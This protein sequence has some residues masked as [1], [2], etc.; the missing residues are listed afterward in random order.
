MK[1]VFAKQNGFVEAAEKGTFS[2]RVVGSE[3]KTSGTASAVEVFVKRTAFRH[4]QRVKSTLLGV[5]FVFFIYP[6]E[7][8]DR[9]P[10]RSK[11]PEP[12]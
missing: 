6:S 11:A 2:D 4:K 1:P 3:Q 9:H 10:A 7:I 5:V 12:L 8:F